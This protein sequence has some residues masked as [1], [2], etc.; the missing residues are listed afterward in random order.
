VFAVKP[1]SG[2]WHALAS[3]NAGNALSSLGEILHGKS[4]TTVACVCLACSHACVSQGALRCPKLPMRPIAPQ[5]ALRSSRVA[6]AESSRAEARSAASRR[7]W[8]VRLCGPERPLRALGPK[9][10]LAAAFGV[11]EAALRLPRRLRAAQSMPRLTLVSSRS[12]SQHYRA[13]CRS[14]CVS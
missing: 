9:S 10:G 5:K 12:A 2:S 3:A 4:C 11:L 13:A 6:R 8:R 1:R 14:P 7:D